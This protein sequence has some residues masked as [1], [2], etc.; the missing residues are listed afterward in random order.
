M[1]RHAAREGWKG[2]HCEGSLFGSL[3]GLLFWD[4]LFVDR[5]DVFQTPYQVAPLDFGT[6]DFY[7]SRQRLISVR[8]AEIAQCGD[9][10]TL[11]RSLWRKHH[12]TACVGVSWDTFTEASLGTIAGC[13]GPAVVAGGCDL[14][15]QDY[16]HRRGGMPDLILYRERAVSSA[17]SSAGSD[18]P[19]VTSRES[20]FVEVKSPQD[21][22][23]PKQKL[24]LHA[25]A[26]L[27]ADVAV[28]DVKV[29][30]AVGLPSDDDKQR[31]AEALYSLTV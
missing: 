13:L 22:L 19:A 23:A 16:R 1:L 27:G 17:G 11:V 26:E 4:I 24:W 20:R 14:L 3:F 29:D 15:A 28:C 25:L 18:S 6:D 8:L 5:P 30:G 21:R 31:S 7:R 9:L 12:R 2:V 10:G